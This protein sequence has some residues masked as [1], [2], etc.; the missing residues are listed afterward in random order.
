M[1]W[2][3]WWLSH[4]HCSCSLFFSS[5]SLSGTTFPFLRY[6]FGDNVK[7]KVVC[8]LSHEKVF[9]MLA[10]NNRIMRGEWS[11]V[12]L[13]T[14]SVNGRACSG[15]EVAMWP[16]K[17]L[18]ERRAGAGEIQPVTGVRRCRKEDVRTGEMLW[19]RIVWYLGLPCWAPQVHRGAQHGQHWEGRELCAP[20]N[21]GVNTCWVCLAQSSPLTAC[22]G[23]SS[24]WHHHFSW[25]SA[26][27]CFHLFPFVFADSQFIKEIWQIQS[28]PM[29]TDL[30]SLTRSERWCRLHLLCVPKLKLCDIVL[31]APVK[32]WHLQIFPAEVRLSYIRLPY[33]RQET[34][35]SQ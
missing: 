2:R 13:Y 24:L 3:W 23:V 34:K 6:N 29:Q 8:Y 20:I 16:K 30:C 26:L 7:G 27:Y 15:S 4:P 5:P 9:P 33:I 31:S 17:L 14:V 22:S 32:N 11:S 28:G 21:H 1:K 19:T 12:L 35:L 18:L 10:W 25:I